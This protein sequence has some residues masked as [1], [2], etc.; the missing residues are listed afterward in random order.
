MKT[1]LLPSTWSGIISVLVLLL[2][3]AAA[4]SAKPI[5]RI[6]VEAGKHTRIDT[7]VSV[8]LAGISTASLRLEEI[9][10]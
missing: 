7:P 5:A 2:L 1:T 10:V 9:K 3:S 6:T 4:I 8:S